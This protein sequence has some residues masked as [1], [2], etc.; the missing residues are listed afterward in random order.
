M[1]VCP[2]GVPAPAAAAVHGVLLRVGQ[3]R[4]DAARPPLR[5]GGRHACGR[6]VSVSISRAQQN[7]HTHKHKIVTSSVREIEDFV[8]T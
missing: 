6:R 3:L 7:Q 4:D 2:P 1:R 8:E 5:L